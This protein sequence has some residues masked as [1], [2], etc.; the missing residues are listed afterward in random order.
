VVVNYRT[1][2]DLSTFCD[3][4]LAAPP[5]AEWRLTVVNSAAQ[6]EDVLMLRKIHARFSAEGVGH[7]LVGYNEHRNVGYARGCNTASLMASAFDHD[8]LAFFNADVVLPPGA[9][10]ACLAALEDHDDWAV[11]GPRQLDSR[12]RLTHA[13]I[14]GTLERPQ[15]RA[16]QHYNGDQY[17]DVREAVTVSGSAYFIRRSVWDELTACPLYREVA[18]DAKGAFLPTNHYFEETYCSYHAQAHGWKVMYYGPVC[19][20]HEWHKASPVGG[21]AETQFPISR[22]YF[23]EAC[24]VHGIKHD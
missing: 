14:F 22:R 7:R 24:D 8:Y 2:K 5:Q 17:G 11:L 23:R 4:I 20:I 19:V 15:H 18:P 16:W 21:W 6:P 3:S 9:V 10:D 12:G 1:P 13:G